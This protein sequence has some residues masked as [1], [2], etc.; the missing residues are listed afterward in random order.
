MNYLYIGTKF[1]ETGFI[2]LSSYQWYQVLAGSLCWYRNKTASLTS[3]WLVI[4][5]IFTRYICENHF[6]IWPLKRCNHYSCIWSEFLHRLAYNRCYYGIT[7]LCLHFVLCTQNVYDNW[8]SHG[9]W[10]RMFNPFF[11]CTKCETHR[12]SSADLCILWWTFNEW[13]NGEKG[14]QKVYWRICMVHIYIHMVHGQPCEFPQVPRTVLYEIMTDRVNY[15]KLCS[16]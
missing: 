14:D 10:N 2:I 16:H 15:Q 4:W 11:K 5:T 9:L 8:R 6:P 7:S 1:I 12:D 13:S 3:H